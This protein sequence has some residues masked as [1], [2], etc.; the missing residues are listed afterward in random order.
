MYTEIKSCVA[1]K[2]NL[3]LWEQVALPNPHNLKLFTSLWTS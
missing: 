3:D 1:E 2:K